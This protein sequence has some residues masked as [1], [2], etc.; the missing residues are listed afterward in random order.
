MRV[1]DPF[2]LFGYYGNVKRVI[3]PLISNITIVHLIEVFSKNS[4]IM[5]AMIL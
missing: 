3:K 5:N 1:E 4:F 2:Y